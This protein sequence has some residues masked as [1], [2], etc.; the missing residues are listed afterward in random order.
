M[1]EREL[2]TKEF[3]AGV[4]GRGSSTYARVKMFLHAGRRLVELV[5]MPDGA[6]VLDVATGRG[7]NLFPAAEKVG[8]TGRVIGIDLAEGMVEETAAEVS[9]RRFK[10]AE[11]RLMD[12]EQLEF[13]DGSFDF[14]LCSFGLYFFPRVHQ[15]FSEF[16]RV[17]KGGGGL[18]IATPGGT[19]DGRVQQQ[20]SIWALLP[21]YRLRSARSRERLAEDG[22]LW[23]KAEA[24][25]WPERQAAGAL[26]WPRPDELKGVL[27]Q[28]GFIDA[29]FVTE[30]AEIVAEDEE[31]WW[32]WQWSHMPRS[33]LELLEPDL[34]D[35]LKAEAFKK[36]QSRK[37]PDGIHIQVAS[38]F[39][40]ATKPHE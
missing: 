36:L 3:W 39:T 9:Q 17:L 12:A 8:P 26:S 13:P 24:M 28:A 1:S 4:Y 2:G 11:V 20:T 38:M 30:E 21:A 31:E 33:Q 32:T 7:A 34:L 25:K 40:F 18:A 16:S 22:E 10:N 5:Q 19:P 35:E 6:Q 27:D 15:V 23:Q 14:V 37:E 29:R